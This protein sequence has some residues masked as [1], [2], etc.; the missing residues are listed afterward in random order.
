MKKPFLEAGQIV[1]THGVRGELKI[2]PWADDPE[3]LLDFDTIYLGG[4]PCRVVSSRVQKTCVLMKLEGIDD[5]DAAARLRG[6]TVCIRRE[7]AQLPEGTMFIAD[8]IGLKVLCGDETIGKVTEILQRPG[9]D[10]YVVKGAHEYLIPAVPEFILERD[11]DEGYIRVR[12]IEGMRT[13]EI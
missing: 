12:L 13:D 11:P 10:V 2:M 1:S 7:D 8:L 9:N 3:F 5:V 4:K 6:Q